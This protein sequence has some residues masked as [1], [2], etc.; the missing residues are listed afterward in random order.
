MKSEIKVPSM[1]ESI[2]EAS[3]CN[4]LKESGSLVSIDEKIIELKTD[5]RN[6][7]LL[8]PLKGMLTL[9]VRLQDLV[10]VGEVIGY[11]ESEENAQ[12]NREGTKNPIKEKEKNEEEK[13]RKSK[14][15]FLK[16]LKDS[17]IKSPQEKQDSSSLLLEDIPDP[18]PIS[19]FPR[20]KEDCK[21]IRKPINAIRKVIAKRLLEVQNSTVSST[22]FNEVDLSAVIH[23]KNLYKD[24]FKRRHHVQLSSMSFVVKAV[25]SS[26]KNIPKL[27]SY[28]NEG[29]IVERKYYDIGIALSSSND[30][31]VPVL[32]NCDILNFAMIET[33]IAH[34]KKKSKEGNVSIEDLEGGGFTI[35][36]EGDF[37]SLLSAPALNPPQSGT[38]G[39]YKIQERAVVVNGQI[40]IRPM[41]Y[42]ALT[43]DHSLING[44]EAITFLLQVKK[45]LEDPLDEFSRLFLDV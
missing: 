6:Q 3:I 26:L 19:I 22:T 20:K 10:Q 9:S 28:I 40:E 41:M 43:Y 38:L 18:D 5:K 29:D 36:D 31:F 34:F 7:A 35:I 24:D 13:S 45:S 1:G 37:G 27:N 8:S 42:L 17:S 32:R 33:A 12:R 39:M 44:K 4:I 14:N 21:E 23:L 11:V 30:L 2:K 25:V 15:D 16:E